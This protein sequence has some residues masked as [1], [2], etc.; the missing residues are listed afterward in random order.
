MRKLLLYILFICTPLTAAESV[1]RL[2]ILVDKPITEILGDLSIGGAIAFQDTT[3]NNLPDFQL[4]SVDIS[5]IKFYIDGTRDGLKIRRMVEAG[6]RL[7]GF[8]SEEN[9]SGSIQLTYTVRFNNLTIYRSTLIKNNFVEIK[10]D[11]YGNMGP[12][13][14][15][16]Y[17]QFIITANQSNNN[18]AIQMYT[19]TRAQAGLCSRGPIARIAERIMVEESSAAMYKVRDYGYQLAANRESVDLLELAILFVKERV[20]QNEK[21]SLQ[22]LFSR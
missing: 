5:D 9:T 19:K 4:K 21:T 22:V 1:T 2:N 12:G 15:L 8:I 7:H 3:F 16:K 10:T 13:G 18:T 17:V 20:L 14:R 11:V 6:K